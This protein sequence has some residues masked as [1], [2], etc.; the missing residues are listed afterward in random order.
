[1]YIL[2]PASG[3]PMRVRKGT[4]FFDI[5]NMQRNPIYDGTSCT[6]NPV[7]TTDALNNVQLMQNPL[8]EKYKIGRNDA[9]NVDMFEVKQEVQIEEVNHCISS[10]FFLKLFIILIY[11]HV[12]VCVFLLLCSSW[13][14]IF[15]PLLILSPPSLDTLHPSWWWC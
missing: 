10:F 2:V 3:G 12:C 1:M 8:A 6:T 13:D 14:G 15:L 9:P 7:S 11:I 5:A 4:E